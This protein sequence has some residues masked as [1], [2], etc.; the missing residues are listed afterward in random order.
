VKKKAKKERDEKGYR[1][2]LCYDSQIELEEFIGNLDLTYQEKAN[3]IYAFF[4]H[5]ENF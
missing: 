3:I 4:S 2:N 1:E 5:C